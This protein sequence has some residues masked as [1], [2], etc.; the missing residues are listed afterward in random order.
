MAD[1]VVQLLIEGLLLDVLIGVYP[2]ERKKKQTI[3]A[4]ITIDYPAARALASDD[5]A[6]T[7]NYHHWAQAVTKAVGATKF[8]LLEVLADFILKHLQAFDA[9]VIGARVTVRK[10]NI[11]DNASS[12]GITLARTFSA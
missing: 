1:E 10:L 3:L 9:R 2:R 5:V 7:L 4:D 8:Q 12:C 11:I 6:D